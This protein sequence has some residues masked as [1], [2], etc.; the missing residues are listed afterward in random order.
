MNMVNTEELLIKY[1]EY[2]TSSRKRNL[3]KKVDMMN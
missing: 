2:L 3:I 1:F